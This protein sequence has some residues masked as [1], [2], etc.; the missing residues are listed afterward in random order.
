M[1]SQRVPLRFDVYL[2]TFDP[3]VGSEIRKTR[4]CVIVSPN[5][6]NRTISTVIIVPF[7]KGKQG[8]FSRVPTTFR[9]T[10]GAIALDQIRAVD[11]SRLIKYEGK[12]SADEAELIMDRLVRLFKRGKSDTYPKV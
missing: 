11:K 4:P 10:S 6:Q 9:G 5:E 3:T 2:V 7:T 8:Y 12:V 1:V